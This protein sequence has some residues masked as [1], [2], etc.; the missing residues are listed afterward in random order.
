M[1]DFSSKEPGTAVLHFNERGRPCCRRYGIAGADDYKDGIEDP[2]L[3]SNPN[4][5]YQKDWI[6]DMVDFF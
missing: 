6:L 1:G 4:N 5:V 3:P 2:Y